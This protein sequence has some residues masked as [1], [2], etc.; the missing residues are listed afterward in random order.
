MASSGRAAAKLDW[1]KLSSGLGLR[2]STATQLQA[3]KKRNDDA[4]RRVQ[5]LSAAPQTVD[6]AHYRSVLKNQAVVDEIES[7]TKSFKPATYDVSKQIKAIEAYEVS[8]V[9]SAEETKG[10]VEKEL[11]SLE[12]TLANIEEARPF[13]Q[14]TLDD[15]VAAAPEIEEKTKELV[16][17]GRWVPPGYKEKF[18]DLSVL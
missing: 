11:K 14:L 2:G 5:A 9:K 6:F 3:F 17:K 1:T 13:E 12:K 10:L 8:A 18:G 4:R 7:F 15:I 16:R